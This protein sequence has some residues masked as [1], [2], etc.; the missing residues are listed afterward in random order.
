MKMV[1]LNSSA[2]ATTAATIQ[3]KVAPGP[4]GLAE[5]RGDCIAKD[6]VNARP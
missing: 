1:W 6:Q 2:T 5:R 3:V 4:S